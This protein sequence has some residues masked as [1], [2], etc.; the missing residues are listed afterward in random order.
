MSE[1]PDQGD[2]QSGHQPPTPPGS[3]GDQSGG[4]S[5]GQQSAGSGF[6]QQ[7]A[8]GQDAPYGQQA[9]YGQDAPYGQQA[10]YGQGVP[11]GR[12]A[13][14]ATDP[15]PVVM[16]FRPAEKQNRLTVAFRW[17]MAI[18]VV[19]VLIFV[20]IAALVVAFL[21][22]WAALFT[23]R[24]PT[25]V[26]EFVTGYVRWSVRTQAYAYLLTDQYPPFSLDDDASYPVRVFTRQTRLNRVAVFFRVI[27]MIPAYIV[28]GVA[29]TGLVILGFFAWLITLFTG[30]L[31]DSLHEAFTAITRYYG[32]FLGYWLLVTPEYPA[33]LY[34]DAI[35]APAG[36]VPVPSD[37]AM[38]GVLQADAG[39][40]ETAQLTGFGAAQSPVAGNPWLLVLS[41]GART[42]VTVALVLGALGE[43]GNTTYNLIRST[44]TVDRALADKNVTN[45]YDR[46]GTV[47]SGFQEKTQNCQQNLACVT[48]LDGQVATAFGSFGQ[49]L[50]NA[51]VPS[52]FSADVAALT[53]DNHKVQGDFSQLAAT[54]SASQYTSVA[55][56]LSLQPDL[57]AWQGAF[58][59]LHGELDKP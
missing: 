51:D 44:S 2:Y 18:P 23:G 9:A 41:S 42:L 14:L 32:R 57:S 24:L 20:G 26:F 5:W 47:L 19:F 34:G 54:K 3:D 50:A 12:S 40:A 7:A 46:L 33:G 55:S 29:G 30:K 56:S 37:T 48:D 6:G 13:D 22:W 16:S 31:P 45:A 36:S 1:T 49:S 38:S 58:N 10:S 15:S 27:L 35:A 21:G 39:S 28:A 52:D 43:I 17:L 53:T 11:Y 59:K 8:Y 25:W 4:Q